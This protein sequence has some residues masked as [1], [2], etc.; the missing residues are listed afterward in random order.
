VT[1]SEHVTSDVTGTCSPESDVV[2]RSSSCCLYLGTCRYS[3]CRRMVGADQVDRPSSAN[4]RPGG[5]ERPGTTGRRWRPLVLE[6][7][8]TGE[9]WESTDA[10]CVRVHDSTRSVH[11]PRR[12]TRVVVPAYQFWTMQV[13][14]AFHPFGIGNHSIHL[15]HDDYLP[16]EATGLHGYG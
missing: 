11:T 1:S 7:V 8:A 16:R 5:A 4:R 2:G 13:N 15:P 6:L 14:L 3:G 12:N 10:V 9:E